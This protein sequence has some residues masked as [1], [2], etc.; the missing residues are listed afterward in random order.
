[1]RKIV[2]GL[3]AVA[4]AGALIVCPA[5]ASAQ[6]GP[7]P[8]VPD[9][10]EVPAAPPA[11]QP[12]PNYAPPPPGV[13]DRAAAPATPPPNGQW[14]Y[15][16]QYGWVWMPYAQSYTYVNPAGDQA[17]AYVYY[18]SY[19][20]RWVGAPW[21]FG[22]GPGP[23]WGARGRAHYVWHARPWFHARYAPRPRVVVRPVTAHHGYYRAGP[24]R[25]R[26]HW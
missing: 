6:E 5:V 23:Y 21:V 17:Y 19:G 10:S 22:V 3:S 24:V 11:S 7:P 20:W 16:S 26:R 25:H 14:V 18:P 4:F 8:G 13:P 2:F 12:T 9:G 15:T 1:M